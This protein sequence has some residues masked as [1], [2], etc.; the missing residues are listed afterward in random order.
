MC[1]TAHGRGLRLTLQQH[2]AQL[3][4]QRRVPAHVYRI[5]AAFIVLV[6]TVVVLAT[7]GAHAFPGRNGAIAF[8]WDDY[9]ETSDDILGDAHQIEHSIR[10]GDRLLYGCTDVFAFGAESACDSQSYRDPAFSPDG[11]RIV[12]DAGSSLAA[13]GSDGEGYALLPDH[14]GDDGTPAFSPGGGR[15]V[16]STGPLKPRRGAL[17]SI[18][19]SDDRGEQPRRLIR[20]GTDPV[21]SSR[22]WIAFVRSDGIYRI[23]PDGSGLRLL[24]LGASVPAWSPDGK[25]LAFAHSG[26]RDELFVTGAAGRATRLL[27]GNG[28][29]DPV[30]DMVWSPDGRRLLVQSTFDLFSI[31]LRGSIIHNFGEASYDGAEAVSAMYGIDWQPLP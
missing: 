23:R 27:R 28:A 7:S 12:L 15:I 13:I 22:N 19:V 17:R 2:A 16:F 21:W 26:R 18:W 4:S 10:I 5:A 1:R 29:H 3:H 14:G 8:G 20:G 31:D 11:G 24:A 30:I 9:N 25:Q 6:V